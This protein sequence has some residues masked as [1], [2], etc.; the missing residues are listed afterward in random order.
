M[1]GIGSRRALN[2]LV[3]A[4]MLLGSIEAMAGCGPKSAGMAAGSG[5]PV[6]AAPSTASAGAGC[7]QVNSVSFDKTKF[8]LHAG[9]AFGAFHHF[10]YT[11]YKNGSFAAGAHGRTAALVKAGLAGAF[12][13]HELNIAKQDA[14]SDPHLCKLV[15]PFDEASAGLSGLAAKIKD[16]TAGPQ[17]LD[18]VNGQVTTL[19]QGSAANGVPVPDQV[20]SDAQLAGGA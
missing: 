5:T 4:L 8:V 18:K 12:T 9:L 13:V 17:D 7:Q 14:E 20:P 10:I 1:A 3:S 15:A 11:P 2:W 19:Q 16:G 6:S